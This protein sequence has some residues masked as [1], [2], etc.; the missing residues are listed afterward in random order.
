MPN[1]GT[2]RTSYNESRFFIGTGYAKFRSSDLLTGRESVRPSTNH[3][4]LY[5]Y[6][7]NLKI[8][9]QQIAGK[10]KLSSAVDEAHSA[11]STK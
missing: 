9:S 4:C 8:Q 11:S 6:I 3:E 5:L 2:E 10:R 1:G 7:I